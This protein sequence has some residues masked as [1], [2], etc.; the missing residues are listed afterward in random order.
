MGMGPSTPSGMTKGETAMTLSTLK[1]KKMAASPNPNA[2]SYFFLFIAMTTELSTLE[3]L[4]P[5]A[6]VLVG[7]GLRATT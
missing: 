5:I 3:A 2:G 7:L 1:Y 6:P 4:M